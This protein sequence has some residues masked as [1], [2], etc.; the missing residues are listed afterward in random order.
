MKKITA[1]GYAAR[2]CSTFSSELSR[3]ARPSTK[4]MSGGAPARAERSSPSETCT[5][6]VRSN[7]AT[8]VRNESSRVWREPVSR[9]ISVAPVQSCYSGL[10]SARQLGLVF[11]LGAT[12]PFRRGIKSPL[13]F[14]LTRHLLHG[15][16]REATRLG[17][18]VVRR[19][20]PVSSTFRQ[21]PSCCCL[22]TSASRFAWAFASLRVALRLLLG[23]LGI[24]LGLRLGRFGVAFGLLA[25]RSFS[26]SL[27]AFSAA[28]ASR[29]ACSRAR[30][31]NS[32]CSFVSSAL[33]RQPV[34]RCARGL[35]WL[36]RGHQSNGWR[37]DRRCGHYR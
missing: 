32:R 1:T 13:L 30:F 3:S 37:Y 21:R 29:S 7:V 23:S 25:R 19:S 2:S 35:D 22:A 15:L 28:F 8:S 14:L 5:A 26:S 17:L 9:A 36:R 20:W 34:A 18:G 4:M 31:I 10:R 27:R 6:V 12:Q 11:G 16:E 33:P 24:T